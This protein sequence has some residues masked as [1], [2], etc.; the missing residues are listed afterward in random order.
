MIWDG[1]FTSVCLKGNVFER[2]LTY[3]M[4]KKVLKKILLSFLIQS[5]WAATGW[6]ELKNIFELYNFAQLYIWDNKPCLL[7]YM[8]V[9]LSFFISLYRRVEQDSLQRLSLR[10]LW[11]KWVFDKKELAWGH[12]SPHQWRQ[13]GSIMTFSPAP[14]SNRWIIVPYFCKSV[15]PCLSQRLSSFYGLLSHCYTKKN[16]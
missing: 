10:R 6:F 2:H 11:R 7:Q 16:G 1:V 13:H 14:H 3:H 12:V 8:Q 9:W 4:M 15:G 5:L